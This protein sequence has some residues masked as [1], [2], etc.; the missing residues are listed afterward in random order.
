MSLLRQQTTHVELRSVDLQGVSWVWTRPCGERHPQGQDTKYL[1]IVMSFHFVDSSLLDLYEP[2]SLSHN[3][4]NVAMDH[5]ELLLL[6][7]GKPL[8]LALVV[9]YI[10]WMTK[11]VVTTLLI[12]SELGDVYTSR[13]LRRLRTSRSLYPA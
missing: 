9:H 1:Q 7:V 3:H 2:K 10:S 6:Y 5:Q 8:L 12:G 13:G 11:Q 4:F